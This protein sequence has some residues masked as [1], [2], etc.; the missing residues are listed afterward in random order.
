MNI[1]ELAKQ[2]GFVE[3]ELD[4]GTTEAFDKRYAK[5][6]NLVEAAARADEREACAN[7]CETMDSTSDYYGLRVELACAD[8]IRERGTT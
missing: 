6:A 3:Y 7:L 2:A 4:D 5:F 8:A 1:I